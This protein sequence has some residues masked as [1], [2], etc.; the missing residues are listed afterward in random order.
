MNDYIIIHQTDNVAVVLRPFKKGEV[1]EGVTLLEDIPQAHKVAL[2]EIKKDNS[3]TKVFKKCKY[4]P[5]N[6]INEWLKLG[7]EGKIP[8]VNFYEGYIDVQRIIFYENNDLEEFFREIESGTPKNEALAKIGMSSDRFN[9]YITKA[10]QKYKFY[11]AFYRDYQ[12]SLFKFV[13]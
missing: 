8:F 12:R 2:K 7:A 5:K 6:K 13:V 9:T 10:K 11:P 3:K 1:V 4:L